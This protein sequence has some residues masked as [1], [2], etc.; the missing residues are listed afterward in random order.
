LTCLLHSFDKVQNTWYLGGNINSG[1]PGGLEIA[2]NLLARC[3]I[4]AH[5]EDKENSGIAVLKVVTRKYTADEVAAL[6][7]EGMDG[8]RDKRGSHNKVTTDVRVLGVGEHKVL[9]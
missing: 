4:S 2:R 3:W 1:S 6:L 9:P 5:D 8:S 7:E